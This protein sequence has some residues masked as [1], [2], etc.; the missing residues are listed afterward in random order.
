MSDGAESIALRIA[1]FSAD[2]TSHANECAKAPAPLKPA[3]GARYEPNMALARTMH[4]SGVRH[5]L[6]FR[7]HRWAS[8]I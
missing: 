3:I 7:G 5:A 2:L 6:A 1:A 8:E 4:V